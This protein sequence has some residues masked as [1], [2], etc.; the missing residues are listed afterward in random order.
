MLRRLGVLL[1]CFGIILGIS[2][3]VQAANQPLPP[4]WHFD[5]Y[6]V[7][8]AT[9]WQ[10]GP[11]ILFVG[12]IH[13]DESGGHRSAAY[14]LQ[15]SVSRGDVHIIPYIN[16]QAVIMHR[17]GVNVD[18][19]RIFGEPKPDLPES[20]VV[21]KLSALMQN[22]DYILTLHDGSGYYSPTYQNSDRN[23]MRYGQ[24]HIIDTEHYS[25]TKH[26]DM[27]L[28]CVADDV[29][30][31]VNAEI[32]DQNH[33]FHVNNT[34]TGESGTIHVE[35]R[36]SLTYYALTKLGI[37]AFCSEASKMLPDLRHRVRYHLKVMQAFVDTV[38]GELMT[39][40]DDLESIGWY[41]EDTKRLEHVE[42]A[43]NG[44]ARRV[45]PWGRLYL[46]PG[47]TVEVLGFGNREHHGWT[48]DILGVGSN[49]DTAIP[50]AV[51]QESRIVIRKE[52]E[53]QG[54][55]RL[56]MTE[57]PTVEFALSVDGAPPIKLRQGEVV[58]MSNTLVIGEALSRSGSTGDI[59]N[60]SGYVPPGGSPIPDD[61]HYLI[62][63]EELDWRYSVNKRGLLYRVQGLASDHRTSTGEVYIQI[64][65]RHGK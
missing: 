30:S 25:R 64:L 57:N 22:Y 17:R 62:T 18:M 43:I 49:V 9:E 54:E 1:A 59:V 48:A 13:G 47:D 20:A 56:H 14:A 7:P 27:C 60:F 50:F 34:K 52:H 38:G 32:A 16:R 53:V 11:K 28:R 42:I 15:G 31:K 24:S 51:T 39:P 46:L 4:E 33:H 35:Q 61:R 58:V 36:A 45:L 21:R 23:P 6:P 8:R 19:N 41:L 2:Q 63:T 37:P 26:G 65:D 5:V 3:S 44:L 55:I 40:P 10:P 12:G 29:V